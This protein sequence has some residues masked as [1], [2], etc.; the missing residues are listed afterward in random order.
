M[1]PLRTRLQEARRRLGIPWEALERDYLLSWVLAGISQV[2]RL[3]DTLVF[4][5][6]T[7]LRK[8]Y[9]GDYRFSE[10]LDFS[11]V[12]GVPKG[13][14]MERLVRE[15]CAVAVRMLDEYAP[16]EMVCERYTEREPHPGGQEAFTIRA[17]FP[18]HSRLQSRVMIEVTVDEPVLWPVEKRRVIHEYGEPL[19]VEIQVYSIQ[20]IVAEKL[21]ALLQQAEMFERRGWSRSRARD[22]YD[23]WRVLGAYGDQLDMAGFDS[24]LREKCFVRGVSFTGPD[25]FFH[26]AMLTYVEETWEQWLGPLVP[27]LP[28]FGIVIGRL[29]PAIAALLPSG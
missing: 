23:L 22:Y 18:W 27:K 14:D 17:R 19:D 4:K 2:P 3:R 8:C 21:R 24:L 7:A 13:E 12:T 25:D 26:D 11:A 9:F 6:G 10:D 1:R 28:P 29:R 15:A 20:E 16:V 5:G